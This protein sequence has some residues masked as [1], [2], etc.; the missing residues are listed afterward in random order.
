[1]DAKKYSIK[2]KK[3]EKLKPALEI[4]HKTHGRIK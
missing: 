3:H 4:D 2:N 1:V